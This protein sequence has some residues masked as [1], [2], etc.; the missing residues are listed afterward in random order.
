MNFALYPI[1]FYA[2]V[3]L[4]GI[5][6][7]YCA[8]GL[9]QGWGLPAMVVLLTVGAW[10]VGDV[11]YNDYEAYFWEFGQDTLENAWWQVVLFLLTFLVLVKPVH[12]G[13]NRKLLHHDSFAI[14]SYERKLV[15]E[16]EV[17][18][19]I[20]RVF[21]LLLTVW[22]VITL[23][24]LSRVNWD[25]F[26]LFFPYLTGYL[27]APWQR[28]RIGGQFD[29][30]IAFVQ[31]LNIFLT[32]AFGLVWAISHD[33]RTRFLAGF[34]FL[35]AAPYFLFSRTRN[36]MLAVVTPGLLA[37]I[38]I[39]LQTGWLMRLAIAA[40]AFSAVNF[41]MLFVL[42]NRD[43]ADFSVVSALQSDGLVES[44]ADTDHKGLNM[45]QELSFINHF[46]KLGTYRPN[47]GERYWA[48]IVNPIPRGLWPNKP[49]VGLDYAAAR[50]MGQ[51]GVA[52]S[53]QEGV[54]A[55]VSTGMI[56]QGVV[57][58][59]IFG[60]PIF[61]AFLMVLWVALLARQDLLAEEH[62][63]RFLLYAL[64]IILTFNM[65]RD[66]T[67]FVTY[68]FFFGYA[69]VYWMERRRGATGGRIPESGDQ[70]SEVRVQGSGDRGQRS[71]VRDQ[72]AEV[73]TSV[74]RKNGASVREGEAGAET[75]D[76]R[77]DVGTGGT[78]RTMPTQKPKRIARWM[79]RRVRAAVVAAR[80][81]EEGEGKGG[82][83][84]RK[85]GGSVEGSASADANG[86]GVTSGRP[87]QLAVPYR[88]YRRYRG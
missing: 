29:A 53:L 60:G 81:G 28:G 20:N 38:L 43:K 7:A 69:F 24:A 5:G 47:W 68:P 75:V 31:Y 22:I 83:V 80:S 71:D 64:G 72:G 44:V 37:W 50:G 77:R 56:G 10:Y 23:I 3:L 26:G 18:R 57:N 84:L 58:F 63:T 2:A 82:S 42:Q 17:Q 36:V 15:N 85:D 16:G 70:R 61:A 8:T 67:F 86:S 46:M 48:E 11:L 52:E 32:A 1:A 59:G 13:I 21:A 30:L 55:T 74:L 35:L 87:R 62:P 34:F 41:W 65:G 33:R 66:I 9:R 78:V 45:F 4:I 79:P 12:D 76:Q 51:G 14:K 54:A 27:V 73:G 88:N 6:I 19:Q 25:F 40:A 49:K 39:R